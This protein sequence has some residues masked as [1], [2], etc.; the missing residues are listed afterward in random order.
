MSYRIELTPPA[1]KD[2]SRYYRRARVHLDA[3]QS[4]H[5]AVVT[6]NAIENAMDSILA[7]NPCNPA[8]ALVGKFSTTYKVSLDSVSICYT[9]NP[10]QNC[11][12]VRSIATISPR[13]RRWLMMQIENG[14]MDAVLDRLK[15]EKPGSKVSVTSSLLH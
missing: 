3:G 5:P 6:F 1:Q 2:Y 12:V 8:F 14:T 13:L 9:V 15:I 4:E 10:G 11:V 7:V